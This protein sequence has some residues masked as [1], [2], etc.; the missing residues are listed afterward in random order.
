MNRY[1]I[2]NWMKNLKGGKQIAV[3]EDNEKF[4]YI[5]WSEKASLER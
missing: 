4:T 5:W 1:T 2:I 3:M